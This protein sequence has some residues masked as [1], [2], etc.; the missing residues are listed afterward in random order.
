MTPC[1]PLPTVSVVIINHNYA[2]YLREAIDS[3]LDQVGVEVEVV[4]VDD[5]STDQSRL[6]IE[7]YGDRIVPVLKPNGGQASTWN[8]GWRAC[9]GDIVIFL[10][11]DDLLL[12]RA[13]FHA[14]SAWRRG[15]SKIHFPLRILSPGQPNDGA[16]H[17]AFTLDEGN[18]RSLVLSYGYYRAPPTSGNAFPRSTLEQIMPIPEKTWVIGADGY[19]IA[20]AGLL[21]EVVRIDEPLSLYR[22]HGRHHGIYGAFSLTLIRSYMERERRRIAA[23]KEFCERRGEPIDHEPLLRMPSHVRNRIYSLVLEPDKHPFPDDSRL[24]LVWHG[25]RASWTFPHNPLARRLLTAAGFLAL[26]LVPRRALAK[27][28]HRILLPHLRPPL[29]TRLLPGI[30]RVKRASAARAGGPRPL[31]SLRWLLTWPRS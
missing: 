29:L 18:V 22:R 31:G 30:D 11:A 25:V 2:D 24:G 6:I 15:V 3:A 28:G 8:A 26:G 9:S 12:P 5:G 27:W 13:A 10:D 21:G 23:I 16:I 20:L 4:V 19:A 17:P 1:K 14:A 7:S